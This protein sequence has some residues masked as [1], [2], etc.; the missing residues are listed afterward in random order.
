MATV[1]ISGGTGMVGKFVTQLLLQQGYRVIVLTRK[2]PAVTTPG[3]QYALWNVAT[4]TIDATAV[5][6]ADYII[7][8]AGE[9]VADKRWTEKRK[10]EII[11]SRTQSSAL[12]I[13]T[14]QQTPH[15]VKAFIS[16]AA[17]GWYG[18]DPQPPTTFGGFTEA[19]P[20]AT[21][22]LGSTC[23][24]WED[25][26]AAV[27]TLGIRLV[28][29]R[30]GIVLSNTGGALAAFTKP[31]GTGVAAILSSGQQIIS[32][33]T[34]DDVS[35]MFL[36]AIEN[37]AMNGAYNAAAP[38]PVSNKVLTQTLAQ[39]V[40]GRFYM[41]IHVPAWVLKLVVGEMSIEVLKSVTMSVKKIQDAGF[42]F[43]YP[44]IEAALNKLVPR[45]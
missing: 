24:Q 2:I 39:Q 30:I 37:T 15:H 16:A 13:K 17:Q 14:L 38:H 12:L 25:S 20:A 41:P 6:Q 45:A 42:K 33:I 4:Q 27:T 3:I 40:R 36:Y 34:I 7:H 23:Q 22:F 9:G 32:W 8:L 35:R 44:T 5:Q 18:A 26:V 31:L 29:L 19:M 21:D 1:L 10:K 28:K 43:A 11:E